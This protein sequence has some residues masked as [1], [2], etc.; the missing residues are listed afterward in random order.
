[1]KNDGEMVMLVIGGVIVCAVIYFVLQGSQTSSSGIATAQADPA[2]VQALYT[3]QAQDT[4]QAAALSAAQVSANMNLGQSLIGLFSTQNTNAATT[5]QTALNDNSA[6]AIAGQQAQTATSIATTNA[7]AQTQTAAING[8][9]NIQ[10]A[11]ATVAGNESI[12]QS[13][14][15]AQVGV[16]QANEQAQTN[17]SNN[18][19]TAAQR[20]ANA[21]VLS[22]VLGGLASGIGSV[23]SPVAAAV[24]VAATTAQAASDAEQADEV[25]G[26][27]S[28]LGLSA[29]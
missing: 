26:I 20:T 6:Q 24:P 29:L 27:F 1:M 5:N 2:S 4:A 22:N 25:N 16:A 12:A 8:S 3:A 19:V 13:A 9:T 28:S 7:N 23:F 14:A 18:Q 15:N 17:I 11:Q 21:G 10:V